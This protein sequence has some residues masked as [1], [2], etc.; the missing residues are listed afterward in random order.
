M[1]KEEAG[2]SLIGTH[3]L[4]S[5][6]LMRIRVWLN[7]HGHIPGFYVKLFFVLFCFVLFSLLQI[8]RTHLLYLSDGQ[9]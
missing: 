9:K 6:T 2:L 3:L 7:V 1:K 4:F 8:K 5:P